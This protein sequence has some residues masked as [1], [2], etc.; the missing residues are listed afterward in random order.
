MGYRSVVVATMS[1]ALLTFGTVGSPEAGAQLLSAPTLTV[2]PESAEV[3]ETV[4]VS[5]HCDLSYFPEGP[6]PTVELVL[7][8]NPATHVADVPYGQDG[9][10]SASVTVPNVPVGSYDLGLQDAS[11]AHGVP[12]DVVPAP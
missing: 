1:A 4:Q 6:T 5:G 10:F 2:S 9:D 3:G 8:T 7:E 12:F 11:C